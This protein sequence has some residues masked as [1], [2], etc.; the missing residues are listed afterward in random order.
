MD[1]WFAE[2]PTRH[3]ALA[4]GHVASVIEKLGELMDIKTVR[5]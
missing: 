4:V 2:A 3:C 5:I 1:R